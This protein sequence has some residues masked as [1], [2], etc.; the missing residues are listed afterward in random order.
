VCA[1]MRGRSVSWLQYR[2]GNLRRLSTKG[3]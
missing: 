1:W 2:Q 3:K